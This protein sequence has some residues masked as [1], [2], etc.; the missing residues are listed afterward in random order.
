M[1]TYWNLDTHLYHGKTL[2]QLNPH[3]L[4]QGD[5][6]L[7]PD[8]NVGRLQKLGFKWGAIEDSEYKLVDL[9]PAT[10]SH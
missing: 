9:R 3:H 5:L 7:A 8:G 10:Y 2:R 4:K 6:V 1:I